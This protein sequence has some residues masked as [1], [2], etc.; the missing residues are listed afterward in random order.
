MDS[1][2]QKYAAEWF[3]GKVFGEESIK[4]RFYEEK[5]ALPAPLKAARSLETGMSSQWQNRS[6]L[7]IKQGKLLAAYEDDFVY[8]RPVLHYFPTYQSLS[9]EELRGYF[10]W[11]TRL[12]RG[13]L[14]KCQLTYAFLYL[15]ELLNGIGVDSPEDGYR[16]LIQFRDSYGPLDGQILPYLRRWIRD[17][18]VYHCLEP[19]LLANDPAVIHNN[20]IAVLADIHS[21]TD[22]QLLEAVHILAPNW[23]DRSKFYK[24]NKNDMEYILIR[25]LKNVFDHYA[26][27]KRSMVEQF[28]GDYD[29]LPLRLFES[30]VFYDRHKDRSCIYRP[31][32]S[33]VFRCRNGVWSV[34]QYGI[35]QRSSQK[36]GDFIK[37]VDAVMRPYYGYKEILLGT[38]LKWLHK[39]I[40]EEVQALLD[41]RRA[42]E[43]AKAAAEAKR[44]TIDF[45]RLDAIRR[46][47]AVTRDKLIVEEELWVEESGGIS[48]QC[49]DLSTPSA[50]YGAEIAPK[51]LPMVATGAS[52]LAM[53]E[54]MITPCVIRESGNSCP[55]GVGLS[56]TQYRLLHD[57]LYGGSLAWVQQE[58]HILSVLTDGINEA[59]FD[60]FSDTVL[61]PD[62]PPEVIEDYIDELKEMVQP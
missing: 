56:G 16:K 3:Y 7:F 12:R 59:L 49:E 43:A 44:V 27:G 9:N 45:S 46:D 34:Q 38:E 33:R 15:Y 29:T 14:Q 55:A 35:T 61:T 20:A 30:A 53:T 11:R 48:A 51:A 36:L 60:T 52:A 21:H 47:A 58:G 13:D 6:A 54:D 31:D 4:P 18:T 5:M 40:T 24:E 8:D 41:A 62:E 57:L 25:V 22:S 50:P 23:L 42:S 19:E 28:C 17:Y 32:A 10:S 2:R 39:L 26:K 37:T 1:N